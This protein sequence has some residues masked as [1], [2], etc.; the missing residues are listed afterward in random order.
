M[1][2]YLFYLCFIDIN[3]MGF[4]LAY[5]AFRVPVRLVCVSPLYVFVF[6][7]YG[8]QCPYFLDRFT[9]FITHHWACYRTYS[10]VVT[11]VLDDCVQFFFF[12][13]S[14]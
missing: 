9:F 4:F 5:G 13:Y 8:G 2:F 7:D 1:V 14:S 11:L 3:A 12:A 10:P 6:L